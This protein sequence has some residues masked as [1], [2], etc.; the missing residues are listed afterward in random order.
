MKTEHA[1]SVAQSFW[2]AWAI[3]YTVAWTDDFAIK[4]VHNFVGDV[5]HDLLIHWRLLSLEDSANKMLQYNT[6]N[7]KSFYLVY[8]YKIL[9]QQP[10]I[11]LA[12]H[13]VFQK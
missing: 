2:T 3:E 8:K 11:K 4:I 9:N 6:V 12:S 10:T 5:T 13:S 7:Q 1:N